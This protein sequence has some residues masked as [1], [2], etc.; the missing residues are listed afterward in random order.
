MGAAILW[1]AAKLEFPFAPC[2]TTG[3][4][5]DNMNM[6]STTAPSDVL[7]G[8]RERLFYDV[9]P[10]DCEACGPFRVRINDGPNFYMLHKDVF[11]RRIYHF[12]CPRRDP[13]ILDCG[14]NIGVTLLY[15]RMVYPKARITAFEP[16]PA[17]LEY[18]RENLE[19]NGVRGVE[20]VP[21][22]VAARAGS[23]TLLADAKYASTLSEYA[24]GN[25]AAES[26]PVAVSCVRLR[27]YLG[28]PIDFLKMNIE[29]A[30]TEVLEDCGDA[31]RSV[32]AMAVE[33]HHLPGR[34][35]TLHRVLGLLEAQGFDYLIHNFDRETNP[36]C[37]PPF[38][39][40]SNTRYYLLIHARRR[41]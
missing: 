18:L 24:P 37:Q 30:E 31:L 25:E 5:A 7:Q 12:D 27:D 6:T 19:A 8:F 22:A 32:R 10:G 39:L 20:V 1:A 23:A 34:P 36:A 15:F 16:D 38:R 14:S 40:R 21:A 26:K 11:R 33:Y 9:Q 28:E 35:R 13:R 41:D 2:G 4:D 3:G 17:V 29:G